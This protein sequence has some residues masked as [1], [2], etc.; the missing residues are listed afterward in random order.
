MIE[1][2]WQVDL[3]DLEF[4][5]KL[6][7]YGNVIIY[8]A[9]WRKHQTVCVKQITSSNS[10]KN[11]N[12]LVQRELDILSK[13]VHPR[14]CQYLGG[15]T[16][17]NNNTVYMVFEYM[18][19]GNLHEYIT[20]KNTSNQEK[21]DILIS[22]AIGMQYLCDRRPMSIIHRD[23]KPSN[24]LVNKH[25]EVKISDFG[26]SRFLCDDD[27]MKQNNKVVAALN[28]NQ[29]EL[30]YDGIGTVR[31]TAPEVLCEDNY[32][33]LCD[34]YSFGL[35]AYFIWTD[36][37]VPYHD[38]YK[39]H[40]AKI[41]FAKSSN[42]RPFLRHPKLQQGTVLYRLVETCT[43]KDPSL[44]PQSPDDLIDMLKKIKQVLL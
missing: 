44:R 17:N 36:G 16:N 29:H 25:G 11:N 8:K 24:I 7:E 6:K 27:A 23:F 4:V 37:N 15:T 26:V 22:I 10:I 32:N 38:E 20:K 3:C 39:N 19:N 1:E 40:W 13:C 9:L 28:S 18:E 35:I 14:V 21:I 33:H 2:D 34:I 31:W 5:C 30:T 43:E 12:K 41:G 42:T